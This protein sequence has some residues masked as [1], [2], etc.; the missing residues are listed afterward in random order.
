MRISQ[1]GWAVVVIGGH[2]AL[3]PHVKVTPRGLELALIAGYG[4]LVLA[5]GR[6]SELRPRSVLEVWLRIGL[7]TLET[8]ASVACVTYAAAIQLVPVDRADGHPT[9]PMSQAALALLGFAIAAIATPALLIRAG[10][11]AVPATRLVLAG[12]AV[13]TVGSLLL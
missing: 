12:C 8:A 6:A 5:L 13:A 7:A 4:L 9:M 10:D 2:A 1:V 3:V 11:R